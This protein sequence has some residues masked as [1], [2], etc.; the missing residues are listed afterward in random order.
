VRHFWGSELIYAKED[1]G[2]DHRGADAIAPIFAMF[3]LTPE[4]RGD[5]YTRLSY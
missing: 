1:P 3:D 5:W 4:G 2:Q